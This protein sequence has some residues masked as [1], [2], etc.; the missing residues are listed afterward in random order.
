MVCECIFYHT[1]A[2]ND[3]M[4]MVRGSSEG[5]EPHGGD[6]RL[7]SPFDQLI[8]KKIL[9]PVP[10]HKSPNSPIPSISLEKLPL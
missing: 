5:V 4:C 1:L 2:I 8:S 3:E 10:I 7:L 6:N 9:V